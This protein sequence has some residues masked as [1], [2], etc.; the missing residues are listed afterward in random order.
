MHEVSQIETFIYNDV[1]EILKIYAN[2]SYNI[3][4]SGKINLFIIITYFNI[5]GTLS[6][7]LHLPLN[8]LT[9]EMKLFLKLN[10]IYYTIF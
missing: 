6:R 1:F 5:M 9:Q 2:E 8:Y 10:N 3:E 7:T 4:F